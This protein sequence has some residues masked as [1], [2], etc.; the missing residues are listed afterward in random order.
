MTEEEPTLALYVPSVMTNSESDQCNTVTTE[1]EV[2]TGSTVNNPSAAAVQSATEASLNFYFSF[3]VKWS[4]FFSFL[5]FFC[6]EAALKLFSGY[7][8]TVC[9]AG[10]ELNV[11]K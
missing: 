8:I 6:E 7:Y 1:N 4:I 11:E 10:I 3:F 5:F 2:Q 9:S